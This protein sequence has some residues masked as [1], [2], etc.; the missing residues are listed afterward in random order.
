MQVAKKTLEELKDSGKEICLFSKELSKELYSF[1]P[2]D[3]PNYSSRPPYYDKANN[4]WVLWSSKKSLVNTFIKK[5]NSFS[6]RNALVT[7]PGL[8]CQPSKLLE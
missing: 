8:E 5:I 3:F 6:V 1:S 2:K 4:S 7:Q